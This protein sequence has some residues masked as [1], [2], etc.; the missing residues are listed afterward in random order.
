MK[1][2][3][4]LG[5]ETGKEINVHDDNEEF[6]LCITRQ[7]FGG[8]VNIIITDFESNTKIYGRD[9]IELYPDEFIQN[10]LSEFN[11]TIER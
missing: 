3:Q 5:I 1:L 9:Y 4:I 11:L 7:T 8:N 2:S 6:F 10:V